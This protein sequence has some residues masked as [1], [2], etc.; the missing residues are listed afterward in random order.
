MFCCKIEADFI[1]H[2]RTPKMATLE[3]A[4]KLHINLN[5]KQAFNYALAN[6]IS[7]QITLLSD[8]R[9]QSKIK[10]TEME[11]I[12]AVLPLQSKFLQSR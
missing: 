4:V 1:F 8:K 7:P 10:I 6:L 2:A 12:L 9:C 5:L 11:I 3:T